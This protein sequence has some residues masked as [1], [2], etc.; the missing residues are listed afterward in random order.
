MKKITIM[1]ISAVL[2]LFLFYIQITTTGAR[3]SLVVSMCASGF[4]KLIDESTFARLQD[5]IIS[6][7]FTYSIYW[8]LKKIFIK[9]NN[10]P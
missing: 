9:E 6:V 10:I 1:L 3:Y 5:Y 4:D 2:G 8:L 7:L